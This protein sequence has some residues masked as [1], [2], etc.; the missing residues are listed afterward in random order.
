MQEGVSRAFAALQLHADSTNNATV[1]KTNTPLGDV[2]DTL[3]VWRYKT[4]CTVIH[5]QHRYVYNSTEFV[6][7]TTLAKLLLQCISHP[8]I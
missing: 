2:F 6:Y 7:P 3:V 5:T 8:Q 4:E 1:Y